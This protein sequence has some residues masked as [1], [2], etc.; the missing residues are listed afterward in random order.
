LSSACET[1][2]RSRDRADGRRAA[3]PAA[4]P[5]CRPTS[6][7]D[8]TRRSAPGGNTIG[9]VDGRARVLQ[10]VGSSSCPQLGLITP[11]GCSHRGRVCRPSVPGPTAFPSSH[12]T[13]ISSSP[14]RGATWRIHPTSPTW[15]TAS[16]G[17]APPRLP[18]LSPSPRSPEAVARKPAHCPQ[19]VPGAVLWRVMSATQIPGAMRSSATAAGTT[20]CI[21]FPRCLTP[22]TYMVLPLGP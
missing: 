8:H 10:V 9:A 21:A 6:R 13:R 15:K 16:D 22:T 18:R 5:R 14:P 7:T 4:S 19:K 17:S 2:R 20:K 1:R 3:S 11:E 12:V